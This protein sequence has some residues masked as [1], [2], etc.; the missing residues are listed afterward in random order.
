MTLWDQPADSE[1]PVGDQPQTVV[2]NTQ[3]G[4][5]KPGHWSE[6]VPDYPLL[7]YI[8]MRCGDPC[9]QKFYG[10]CLACRLELRIDAAHHDFT[11]VKVVTWEASDPAPELDPDVVISSTPVDAD[12]QLALGPLPDGKSLVSERQVA[13]TE[14]ATQAAIAQVD[15]NANE[16]WKRAAL[17]AVRL[18]ALEHPEF[19]ADE[20][21]LR[22]ADRTDVDT[23]EPAALGPV[24]LR[25]ARSQW[26]INTN[27]RRKR[28]LLEQRHRELT[29]WRSLLYPPS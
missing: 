6:Q 9:R 1:T 21:W 17:E 10:P 15:E 7:D 8:C 11:P 26:I 28:S 5:R 12:D 2:D 19:T 4:A 14:A 3:T 13:A 25:A 29:I 18:C 24:F 23:H 20:V 22:L 27:R 16:A